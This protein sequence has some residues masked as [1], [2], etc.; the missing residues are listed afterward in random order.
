MQKE[1]LP[2]SDR[3]RPRL[4]PGQLVLPVVK[5]A[6]R[7]R[8]PHQLFRRGENGVQNRL[9]AATGKERTLECPGPAGRGYE[10]HRET[11]PPREPGCHKPRQHELYN[12][13]HAQSHRHRHLPR[14]GC[15]PRPSA[16][17]VVEFASLA[18]RVFSFDIHKHHRRFRL[19]YLFTKS[20]SPPPAR[21]YSP[22]ENI[23]AASE[24]CIRQ[25]EGRRR[26]NCTRSFAG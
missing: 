26:Q 1:V 20:V 9:E 6:H 21:L 11:L 10:H 2:V 13:R 12:K 22:L 4:S 8:N 19:Q 5:P 14:A 23:R 24:W 16:S 15:R 18:A 17:P 25:P 3:V 7:R